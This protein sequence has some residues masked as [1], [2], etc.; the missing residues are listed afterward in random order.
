M[1]EIQLKPGWKSGTKLTYECLGDE[2]PG[3]VA[4]D[5]VFVVK[6]K[7][8]QLFVRAGHNL[9]FKTSVRLRDALLGGEVRLKSLGGR[10]LVV[11]FDGP[12]S[13]GHTQIVSGEGM[14]ISKQPGKFGDL[15]V[16][17][18]VTMPTELSEDARKKLSEIV[19]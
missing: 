17:F 12:I 3:I 7:P 6:E 9:I 1:V 18:N 8:H 4:A 19:F 16:E 14:P 15:I 10:S 2:A 13:T 11:K 5:M